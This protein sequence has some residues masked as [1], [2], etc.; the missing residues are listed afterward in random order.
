[1][2]FTRRW[3]QHLR[4]LRKG[5]HHSKYLQNAWNLYGE[6][7]F[8]F[9]E[10]EQVADPA[11]LLS[12]EQQYFDNLNPAYNMAPVA[13]RPAIQDS[14]I[15]SAR[16]ANMWASGI[17]KNAVE[18]YPVRGTRESDGDIVELSSHEDCDSASFNYNKI[19][20]SCAGLS[21]RRTHKEYSW[22]YMD[23][24]RQSEESA[25]AD[26]T[27]EEVF[28][29]PIERIDSNGTIV[30]YP[31]ISS[32]SEDG[33]LPT[34]VGACCRGERETHQDYFWQFADGSS[35]EFVTK[36][37]EFEISQISIETGQCLRVWHSQAE[38]IEAGYGYP[39]VW[40]CMTGQF[41]RKTYK[42]SIWRQGSDVNLSMDEVAA[43]IDSK[44]SA[45]FR[46]VVRIDINTGDRKEY[47]SQSA[48]EVD[49]FMPT[50]VSACCLGKVRKHRGYHWEFLDGSTPADA[51]VRVRKIP[52]VIH[53]LDGQ[54]TLYSRSSDLMNDGFDAESVL[55][56]CEGGGN[57]EW[58]FSDKTRKTAITE[59]R[60][61]LR[62]NAVQATASDGTI[63]MYASMHEAAL[64]SG[65]I[66]AKIRECCIG[67]RKTHA[68]FAWS[69]IS[70]SA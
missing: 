35:P 69:F 66:T 57:R 59:E 70:E 18:F 20:A 13:G 48:V 15:L 28:N 42:N 52:S 39:T 4:G 2:S 10:I 5:S 8:A 7:S 45:L 56:I 30:S 23:A 50:K 25:D 65:G 19:R 24:L 37:S 40:G 43:I 46:A 47:A 11:Q 22:V 14:A 38:L 64:R 55:A 16:M 60:V 58:S 9:A 51:K 29:R 63:T 1:M 54:E 31:S 36:L 33:F 68:G 67:K 62:T 6:A 41:G 21:G 44:F 32:T 3:S 27:F 53:V 34:N 17:L 26:P 61:T 49:G 12:V